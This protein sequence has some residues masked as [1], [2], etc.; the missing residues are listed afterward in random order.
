LTQGVSLCTPAQIL[1]VFESIAHQGSGDKPSRPGEE[2]LKMRFVT[3]LI[4]LAIGCAEP[5]LAQQNNAVDP[6]ITQQ[7]RVLAMKYDEVFNKSDAAAVAA[8]YTE[9]GIYVAQHGT[10]HGRQAIEKTYASYFRH[11]HSIN[12]VST[13]DRVI[14]V[15]N[16]VRVFGTWTSAFQDIN[17]TPK[18]DGGHYRWL[19][20]RQ[21][22]T[23]KIR[24]NTN[25]SSN[26][27]PIN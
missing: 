9:D 12:L 24:T 27:N 18:K 20:V 16:G 13:V 23:W 5:V 2:I 11:R 22:D 15:G 4:V 1:P 10:F 6:Q 25:R 8:L 17:G 14:A 19:L 7:I 21:G 3:A 26:F